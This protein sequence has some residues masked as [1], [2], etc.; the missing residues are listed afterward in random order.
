MW[1]MSCST[2]VTVI[3]V[4]DEAC[5]VHYNY[6]H[7][8][9]LTLHGEQ[10]D[11]CEREVQQL[12]VNRIHQLTL[13]KALLILTKKGRLLSLYLV[14]TAQTNPAPIRMVLFSRVVIHVKW[15]DSPQK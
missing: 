7:Y 8:G 10:K 11:T 13:L 5:S 1:A 4:G 12:P 15:V 6:H 9:F 2:I 14:L 3:A